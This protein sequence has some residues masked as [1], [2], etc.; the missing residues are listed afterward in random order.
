MIFSFATYG[1]GQ[2]WFGA[3][4][5]MYHSTNGGLNWTSAV[6]SDSP[7]GGF[8]GI[9]FTDPLHGVSTNIFGNYAMWT[10]DGGVTWTDVALPGS[11]ESGVTGLRGDFFVS[12]GKTIYRSAD[13]GK[14]WQGVFTHTGSTPFAQLSFADMGSYVRGWAV[15]WAGPIVT[16]TEIPTDVKTE[17]REAVPSRVALLANYPNPF[18][19]STIITYELP[20]SSEIR[21]AVYDLLGTEVAVL[22]EGV[23][24]QGVHRVTLNASGLASG[25]YVCRL[26]TPSTSVMR[27]LMLIR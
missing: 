11:G 27:K 3:G 1:T 17:P 7:V 24:G 4:L 13:G 18:N 10:E 16:Y 6:H 14:T 26:Q 9:H 15:A 8:A 12:R 20:A 2:L 5:K 19:P 23:R 25:P 22:D 21:L